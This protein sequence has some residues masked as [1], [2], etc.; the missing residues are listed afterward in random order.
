MNKLFIS[1]ITIFLCFVAQLSQA[2]IYKRVDADGRVTYSNVKI[3]GAK[4]LN[5][6]PADTS[7]GNNA[8][9]KNKAESPPKETKKSTTP[10]DFP[11]VDNTTQNKRDVKRKEI[12]QQELDQENQALEAAKLAYEE[13]KNNPE[14][15]KTASGKTFRNVAKYEEKMKNLQA[16]VDAHQRNVDLL[17]KELNL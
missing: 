9:A 12:L 2:E 11:K 5:L 15:Y 1:S 14:V 17:R 4:K 10:G 13:G 6:E 16:E 3:D 7:F 8:P